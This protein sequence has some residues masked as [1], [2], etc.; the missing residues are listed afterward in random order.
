MGRLDRS[1]SVL[2]FVEEMER[3]ADSRIPN[4]DPSE[5]VKQKKYFDCLSD[6]YVALQ[7]IATRRRFRGDCLPPLSLSTRHFVISGWSWCMCLADTEYTHFPEEDVRFIVGENLRLLIEHC[8]DPDDTVC[9]AAIH[10]LLNFGIGGLPFAQHLIADSMLKLMEDLLPEVTEVDAPLLRKLIRCHQHLTYARHIL[11]MPQRQEW[12]SLL[13][14]SL[15]SA[16]ATCQMNFVPGLIQL[17]CSDETPRKT[18]TEEE[19]QVR[20]WMTSENCQVCKE[21]D[22]LL[23]L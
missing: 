2:A 17:W 9:L 16:P 12:A 23:K 20:A 10:V 11:T 14:K 4:G 18:Y 19:L 8:R 13:L 15:Q 6:N 22:M 1:A 21:L 3:S 5:D 7:P